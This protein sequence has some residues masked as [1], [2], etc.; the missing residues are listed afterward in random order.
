MTERFCLI[1]VT[2]REFRE[3]TLPP[4]FLPVLVSL[5]FRKV[6]FFFLPFNLMPFNK[7]H[8]I[9]HI[10][11]RYHLA[12]WMSVFTRL[13]YMFSWKNTFSN[14]FENLFYNKDSMSTDMCLINA[15]EHKA[16]L[17]NWL[18][19]SRPY[20][21]MFIFIN[22]NIYGPNNDDPEFLRKVLNLIPDTGYF[23][24]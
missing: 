19:E 14:L 18:R 17:F 15:E 24:Y 13:A 2:S 3:T 10:A 7:C 23:H 6:L 22:L 4:S 21:F 11:Y 16:Y 20:Y 5:L 12:I 8:L 9:C 1:L